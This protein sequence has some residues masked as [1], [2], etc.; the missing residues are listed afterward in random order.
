MAPEGLATIASAPSCRALTACG[1]PITA[2]DETTTDLR[3]RLQ[4]GVSNEF[5]PV[6]LRHLQV[7]EDDLE[8]WL[9][10]ELLE[11]L[12]PLAAVATT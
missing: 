1:D 12:L 8:V 11:R 3:P 4:P 7:H 6:H 5:E 2:T 10:L 9:A